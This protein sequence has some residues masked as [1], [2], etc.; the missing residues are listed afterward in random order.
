MT[1]HILENSK[2]DD[3]DIDLCTLHNIDVIPRIGD[4]LAIDGYFYIVNDLLWH[5]Y[6]DKHRDVSLTIWVDKQKK[7]Y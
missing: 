7:P 2:D 5:I 6:K 1:I 4:N 3:D